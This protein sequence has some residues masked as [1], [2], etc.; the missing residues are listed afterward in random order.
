[1]GRL[2]E[3]AGARRAAGVQPGRD[4]VAPP[5]GL[6]AG[7]PA[8]AAG[9]R[10]RRGAPPGALSRAGR[11]AWRRLPARARLPGAAARPPAAPFLPF[12]R[13]RVYHGPQAGGLFQ[14]VYNPHAPWWLSLAATPEFHGVSVA[15]GAAALWSGLAGEA[16]WPLPALIAACGVA[17]SAACCL[18]AGF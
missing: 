1:R 13:G 9:L 3:A 17:A 4:R 10:D 2:L 6:G 12:L 18:E 14:S 15:F 11:G 5:A 8:A 16:F 7:L